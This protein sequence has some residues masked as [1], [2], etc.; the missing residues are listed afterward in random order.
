MLLVW[1]DYEAEAG[2][3][4]EQSV[5]SVLFTSP[6]VQLRHGERERERGREGGRN[7]GRERERAIQVDGETGKLH[8]TAAGAADEGGLVQPQ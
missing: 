4:A 8:I 2:S 1:R 6:S 5:N 7:G 3:R